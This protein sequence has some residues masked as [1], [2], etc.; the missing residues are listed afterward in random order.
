MTVP[1]PAIVAP[2]AITPEGQ[3]EVMTALERQRVRLVRLAS[4]PAVIVSVLTIIGLGL[5]CMIP[6]G[7]WGDEAISVLEARMPWVDM[8]R[9]LR[10]EDVHP[11][12]Y[13][14]ILWVTIR[15]FGDGADATRIPSIITGTAIIP[16][17]YL[18][19]KAA[20]TRRAGYAAAVLAVPAPLLVWYSQETRMYSMFML[21]SVV[22][23]WA[24]LRCLQDG[25]FRYWAVF[26]FANAV[27]FYTEYF[28]LLQSV[29]AFVFLLAM[30]VV[31][32]RRPRGGLHLLWRTLLAALVYLALIGPIVP[33]VHQQFARSIN[34]PFNGVTTAN[35]AGSGYT[36]ISVYSVLNDINWGIFGYHSNGVML[37]L[38]A[39]WPVVMLIALVVL[40]RRLGW[41][42][43]FLAVG[44]AVPI[45]LLIAIVVGFNQPGLY[46]IRYDA[47]IVPLLIIAFGILLSMMTL[48]RKTWV[49]TMLAAA[50][51]LTG[52]LVDQ[53]YDW[54]N[55]RLFYY[56]TT[57]RWVA[58]HYRRGDVFEYAPV[59]VN[60][61]VDYYAPKIP[62][63][64]ATSATIAASRGAPAV[65]FLVSPPL[66]GQNRAEVRALVSAVG[67]GRRLVATKQGANVDIWEF[68]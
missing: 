52:F 56:G 23:T 48:R 24:T 50:L 62:A 12:L 37:R 65:F 47:G 68:K 33:F 4:Q 35:L 25:R 53:Q 66:L 42:F 20:A 1:N 60:N 34:H 31:W 64:F 17:A 29:A 15:L 44:I 28:G 14:S 22:V 32:R 27:L 6:R 13:F 43:R 46:D 45:A 21:W 39:F 36:P 63:E 9:F 8:L 54:S 49:I 41:E 11:P 38:G 19:G 16:F 18:I 55:P 10:T 30:V 7:L 58:E 5:R 59:D 26:V 2:G 51:V 3:P 40:G 57:V 61:V 67:H